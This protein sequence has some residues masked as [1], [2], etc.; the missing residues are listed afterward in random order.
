MRRIDEDLIK[1]QD[2]K[3]VFRINDDVCINKYSDDEYYVMV[4]HFGG[5]WISY[6]RFN[7]LDEAI[8]WGSIAENVVCWWRM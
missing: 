1:R 2:S 6:E 5:V 7:S 8:A 4:W 3:T